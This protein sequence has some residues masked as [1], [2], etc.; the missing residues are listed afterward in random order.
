MPRRSTSEYIGEFYHRKRQHSILGDLWTIQLRVGEF[1]PAPSLAI[2]Y[3]FTADGSVLA[4]TGGFCFLP[5]KV[6]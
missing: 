2:V 3:A 6:S 5:P 1:Q 4:P